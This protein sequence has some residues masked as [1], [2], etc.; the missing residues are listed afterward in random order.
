[1]RQR[2]PVILFPSPTIQCGRSI[3]A[4][5]VW[6][7][8]CLRYC[9]RLNESSLVGKLRV[10]LLIPA[11]A[12]LLRI[13]TKYGIEHIHAHSCANSAHLVALANLFAGLPYSVTV[14]GDLKVYGSDHRTKF[15][16]AKFI[17]TVTEPLQKEVL[18]ACPQLELS[19]VPII[20]M[21]VDLARFTAPEMDC[22][23]DGPLRLVSV[24][25]LA[26]VK[27]HTYTLQAL[28]RLP[29]DC[30]YTYE[31]VGDGEMHDQINAEIQGL[32]LQN[33]VQL[34]GFKKEGEVRELLENSDLFLLTSFGLG[35][36]APVAVMEAMACGLA[37]IC[38]IIG[39]TKSMITSGYD[40]VLVKQES[41][42][43]IYTA[44]TRLMNDRKLLQELGRNAR[45]S[46]ELKF[47]HE[48]NAKQLAKHIFC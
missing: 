28:S 29:P 41:I 7:L 17:A 42:D 35:E 23:K 14:H 34:V 11:A 6:L 12:H 36:A 18:E 40:G 45:R 2:I 27:G 46:A 8:K 30:K 1:M 37:V 32:G 13:S 9:V 22:P 31:I 33:Q 38:S 10:A 19:H 21:G 43:E 16:N 4:N 25:R 3:L 24:S 26:H 39:G 15:E 47:S 5:P 48:K 20:P 44:L